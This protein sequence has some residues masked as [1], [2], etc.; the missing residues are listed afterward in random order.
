MLYLATVVEWIYWI[1]TAGRKRPKNLKRHVMECA[2]MTRTFS[3]KKAR[4]RLDYEPVDHRE[5]H[6]KAGVE[7]ILHGSGGLATKVT[8]K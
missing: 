1:F 6:I 8:G 4:K 5:A 7:W 2:T 3:I